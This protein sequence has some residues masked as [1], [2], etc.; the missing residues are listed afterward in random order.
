MYLVDYVWV[1][2]IE[3]SFLRLYSLNILHEDKEQKNSNS[4]IIFEE[5]I[6][7]CKVRA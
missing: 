4:Q 7:L 2:I 1:K 3:M 6:V 5:S